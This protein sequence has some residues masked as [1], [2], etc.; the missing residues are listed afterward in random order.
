MK[1]VL[2][3]HPHTRTRRPGFARQLSVGNLRYLPTPV[4]RP[5][6]DIASLRLGIV[7]LGCS[8]FHRAHQALITQRAIEIESGTTP[9]PW[10]IASISLLHSTV[11]YAL[12]KQNG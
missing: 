9:A 7:H 2:A 4:Q 12:Q 8:A 11:G 5:R 1:T 3:F 6:Y 10:G